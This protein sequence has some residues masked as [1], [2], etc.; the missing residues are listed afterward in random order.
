MNFNNANVKEGKEK[1]YEQRSIALIN[2][3]EISLKKL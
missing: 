2:V 3:E 1:R